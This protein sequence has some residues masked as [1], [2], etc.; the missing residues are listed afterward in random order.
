MSIGLFGKKKYFFTG[1]KMDKF[2]E[3][4][5]DFETKRWLD[6]LDH[7]SVQYEAKWGVGKLES[8]APP[9]LREKWSRQWDKLNEAIASQKHTHVIDLAQGCIRAWQALE[10]SAYQSGHVH[11]APQCWHMAH[12][13]TGQIYRICLTNADAN[14][15]E[16]NTITYT[17]EEVVRILHENSLVHKIAAKPPELTASKRIPFDFRA[18]DDLPF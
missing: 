17:L 14:H 9:P 11:P 6:A 8:L 7:T 5:T 13:D 3:N 10:N 1:D 15:P 12:P 4:K 16:P 18:G 2:I